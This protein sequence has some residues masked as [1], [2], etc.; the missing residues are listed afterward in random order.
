MH[1]KSVQTLEFPKVLAKVAQE[2]GFSIGRERV[3]ALQPTTD[4]AEAAQRLAFTSEA[5]RLR[6]ERLRG[7]GGG[8]QDVRPQL[9]RASR[10][11]DLTAQDLVAVGATLRAARSVAELLET[12]DPE[13]SPQL[14]GLRDRLP[15]H[16]QLIHRIEE[17]VD[18]E[19]EVLD[20]AST[21]LRRLRGDVRIAH[22]RLQQRLRTLVGEFGQALQ[23]PIVTTRGDRYVLPVK[24]DFR[25]RVRGVVH[26]QS[27]S[28]ATLFIEPMAA[29]ELNNR[30]RDLQSQEQEE[31]Q[32]ILREVSE[33]IG[34]E[35]VAI[36]A[37]LEALAELDLQLSK[38]R[39]ARS[40]RSSGPALNDEGRI[41][42]QRA[43]HPLLSGEVVPIDFRLGQEFTMVVITGPNTGGKTVALKTVGLLSLMAQSGLHVPADDGS[44]LTVLEEVFADIGDE[45][46]IEQSLSTFSSHM[47]RIIEILRGVEA[48]R[49]RGGFRSDSPPP[50]LVLLDEVGAGTDPSEGSALARSILTY[51]LDRRVLTIATTHYSELKAFAHAH[52]EV[53]NASVAFDIETL[54][55]TYELEIGVP[56]RSNALAIA[57]RLGLDPRI[58]RGARR[59]VGAAAVRME[60]LLE[61]LERERAAASDERERAETE[62]AG[63]ERRRRELDAERERL[64]EERLG[65]LES[66]RAEAR[67]ELDELVAELARIRVQA[68]RPEEL[69]R[70]GLRSLREEARRLEERVPPPPRPRRRQRSPEEAGESPEVMPGPLQVGDTVRVLSVGQTG[71]LLELAPERGEAEVQMGPMRVRVPVDELERLRARAPAPPPPVLVLRPD[72]QRTAPTQLD[73][74]GWRVEDALEELETYLNDATLSGMSSVRI[75]HGKG[76]GALRS[77][78][79]QHLAR[80]PLVQSAAPAPP[81]EGGD[82]VTIV[83]LIA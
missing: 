83:Q 2:A 16:P 7:A 76:T 77:A 43:R 30:L 28:G 48:V 6:D 63:A 50:V 59:H 57:E 68:A 82:G 25:G 4:R 38:A 39:Y 62:R 17:V 37:A 78:V 67:R 1:E 18:E 8:A 53:V 13:L 56:G 51:L 60:D 10:G 66:A 75:L 40:T 71:E 27:A 35:A 14:C 73:M 74:R 58:V 80:H 64:E 34:A 61:D 9:R 47:T 32:H 12:A 79:R 81:Q 29:L 26:D 21:R 41:L 36:E 49:R 69:T 45:Q 33:Q 52:P 54:S 15:V 19:G 24:T 55:P 72:Q 31:V 23:E 11:G 46:S 3:L 5:F 65:V 42:L 20:T 22:Q 44:E 70:E